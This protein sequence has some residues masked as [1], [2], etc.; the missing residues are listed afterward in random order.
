M[1]MQMYSYIISHY[2]VI[3]PVI[4]LKIYFPIMSHCDLR[5]EVWAFYIL[6]VPVGAHY[7]LLASWISIKT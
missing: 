2:K 4:V 1:I 7:R 5:N 6:T 3:R